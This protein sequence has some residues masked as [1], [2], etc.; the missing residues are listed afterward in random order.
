MKLPKCNLNHNTRDLIHSLAKST[1]ERKCKFKNV[2]QK[3]NGNYSNEDAVLGK[4]SSGRN[5]F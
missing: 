5:L 4:K 3:Y 1:C 2:V